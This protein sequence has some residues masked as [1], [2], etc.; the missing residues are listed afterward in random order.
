M[1]SITKATAKSDSDTSHAVLVA[2]DNAI[3]ITNTDKQIQDAIGLGLYQ[4]TV[5]T[6]G[7]VDA[8]VVF[9][10][11]VDLGYLIYLPDMPQN[12]NLQPAQLFG[13]YWEAFWNHTLFINAGTNPVR[14][15]IT[16]KP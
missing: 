16:W 7:N 15:V 14:M 12:L 9:K 1:S 6:W 13:T 4:T 2:A 11:Y 10:Y 3:W 5:L 8:M